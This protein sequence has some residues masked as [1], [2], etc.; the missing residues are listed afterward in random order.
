VKKNIQSIIE[1]LQWG[2][3]PQSKAPVKRG[4]DTIYSSGPRWEDVRFITEDGFERIAPMAR[5]VGPKYSYFPD[6]EDASPVSNSLDWGALSRIV[7]V[8][9]FARVGREGLGWQPTIFELLSINLE[10][11]THPQYA[12]HDLVAPNPRLPSNFTYP[13]QSVSLELY[14]ALRP[15]LDST[16]LW[17]DAQSSEHRHTLQVAFIF[18]CQKRLERIH[19][20]KVRVLRHVFN[21]YTDVFF[22]AYT[23]KY[24]VEELSYPQVGLRFLPIKTV[25]AARMRNRLLT[26]WGDVARSSLASDINSDQL[27]ARRS[28]CTFTQSEHAVEKRVWKKVSK[29]VYRSNPDGRSFPQGDFVSALAS[30][31]YLKNRPYKRSNLW[32]QAVNPGFYAM[33]LYHPGYPGHLD[34]RPIFHPTA[35]SSEGREH[36][37]GLFCNVYSVME[38]Y[39]QLLG[40]GSL[41]STVLT[42]EL[43]LL[44]FQKAMNF[45]ASGVDTGTLTQLRC[46]EGLDCRFKVCGV[47]DLLSTLFLI[48]LLSCRERQP[49]SIHPEPERGEYYDP[50]LQDPDFWER[51]A[52]TYYGEELDTECYRRL[53]LTPRGRMNPAPILGTYDLS[54]HVKNFLYWL[55]LRLQ[56]VAQRRILSTQVP[57]RQRIEG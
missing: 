51:C 39:P 27:E 53:F 48:D 16:Q 46:V 8:A 12:S 31:G 29:D 25:V 37:L 55:P 43:N 11:V 7:Y 19:E 20:L 14:S 57:T 32:P 44:D 47:T 9:P 1:N 3:S 4:E 56:F 23:G 45:L 34:F 30:V 10:V 33:A 15:I 21:L 54:G 42:R 18:D 26:S 40:T 24:P 2:C 36:V 38:K 17:R 35:V 41:L 6:F 52:P 13:R 22:P 50:R 5:Y 28:S 49:F